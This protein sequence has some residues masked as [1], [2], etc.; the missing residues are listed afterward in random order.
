MSV[1]ILGTETEIR[2]QNVLK[3]YLE[4]LKNSYKTSL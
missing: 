3:F 2:P 4:K 1:S